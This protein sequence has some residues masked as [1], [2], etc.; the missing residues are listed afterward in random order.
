[1]GVNVCLDILPEGIDPEDWSCFY[2]QARRLLAEHRPRLASLRRQRIGDA[3][4]LVYSRVTEH[5]PEDPGRRSLRVCGDLESMETAESFVLY[6]DLAHYGAPSGMPP[7]AGAPADILAVHLAGGPTA[8]VYSEKTQGYPY[9]RAVL[10]VAVLAEARFPGH[11]LASGDITAAQ[12]AEA[13]QDIAD[14]LGMRVSIPVLVDAERLFT[15]L[16]GDAPGPASIERY[17]AAY[18]GPQ[19]EAIRVAARRA[20]REAVLNWLAGC[21]SSGD[22]QLT[23]GIIWL[24]RDWLDATGDLDGLIDAAALR[25]GGPRFE[26]GQLARGLVSSGVSLDAERIAG[27]D[28]LDRPAAAAPSVPSLL[29]NA[30][31]DAMGLTARQCRTRLGTAAVIAH[32]QRFFPEQAETCRRIIESDTAALKQRLAEL[33]HWV[34]RSGERAEQD[35]ELGDGESFIHRR[36]GD[37]L[38]PLQDGVLRELARALRPNW[39]FMRAELRERMGEDVT[40]RRKVLMRLAEHRQLALTESGWAWIDA[41]ADLELLDLLMLLLADERRECL[42]VNLRRGL[43][44][45]R[46]LCEHLRR[47]IVN[48]G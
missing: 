31:L 7:A 38:S 19:E 6:G 43:F 9:H 30:L 35:V 25:F 45:H 39:D 18:V 13:A 27:L 22:G 4:R 12:C 44:E 34:E 24:F 1:M 15:R 17:V 37:P 14:R 28:R 32:L 2:D 41:E 46:D 11:A 23:L 42:L 26:P 20:P 5:D 40:E 47:M 8:R 10:G 16:V 3:T 36:T 48:D 29:G 33:G 21:A